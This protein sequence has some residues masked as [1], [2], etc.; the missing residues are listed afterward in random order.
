[1]S[2]FLKIHK[3]L[4]L[5]CWEYTNKYDV[6]D[7]SGNPLFFMKEE[8]GC[9]ARMCCANARPLEVSFQDLQGQELLRF[10]RPLRYRLI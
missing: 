5:E 8:S 10:D 7:D 3:I 1:M 2:V 9:C 4:V 6:M